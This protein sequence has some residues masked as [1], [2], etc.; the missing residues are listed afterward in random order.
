MIGGR[1]A[2]GMPQVVP[3]IEMENGELMTSFTR[4]H[5]RYQLFGNLLV[6][7]D[8]RRLLNEAPTVRDPYPV[9]P[10]ILD[11]VT[12][13]VER[14][15]LRLAGYGNKSP[16][17][18][19]EKAFRMMQRAVA[20][21]NEGFRESGVLVDLQRAGNALPGY[22]ESTVLQTLDLALRIEGPLWLVHRAIP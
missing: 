12:Q 1:G 20:H 5:L 8:L 6:R 3:V 17:D 11:Q 19:R 22:A 14:S 13:S 16:A 9:D 2:G 4:G 21:A 10:L 7:S 15:T 18:G